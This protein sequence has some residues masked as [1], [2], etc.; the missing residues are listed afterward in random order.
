MRWLCALI[1]VACL[2]LRG[3][4]STGGNYNESDILHANVTH[5]K[6]WMVFETVDGLRNEDIVLL[7]SGSS[8]KG[9]KYVR[10]RYNYCL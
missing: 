7:I 3:N 4:A 8:S 2:F 5:R 10:E 1:S 9:F 6:P